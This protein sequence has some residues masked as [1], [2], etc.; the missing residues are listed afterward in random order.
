LDRDAG[1][2][3]P[4]LGRALNTRK[5]RYTEWDGG[6]LGVE[7]YDITKDP[8]ELNNLSDV[9]ELADVRTKLKALLRQ[10]DPTAADTAK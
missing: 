10:L 9:S 6:K 1:K 8:R 3:R 2:S 4:I 5:W 7:L